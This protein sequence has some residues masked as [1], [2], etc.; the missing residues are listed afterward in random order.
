VAV[1]SQSAEAQKWVEV[2]SD[3]TVSDPNVARIFATHLIHDCCVMKSRID[4][5]SFVLSRSMNLGVLETLPESG[6]LK[7]FG[8]I[9]ETPYF[10]GHCKNPSAI[11]F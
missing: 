11:R 2:P 4:S 8:L 7:R 1:R 6:T 5:G 10:I 3:E 9:D